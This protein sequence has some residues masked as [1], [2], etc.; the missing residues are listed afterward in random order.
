MDQVSGDHLYWVMLKQTFPTTITDT[1]FGACGI[2]QGRRLPR[3]PSWWTAILMVFPCVPYQRNSVSCGTRCIKSWKALVS[4]I[5]WCLQPSVFCFTACLWVFG[6]DWKCSNPSGSL[7][8]RQH[9]LGALYIHRPMGSH[10]FLG[11]PWKSISS[12]TFLG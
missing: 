11:W 9:I 12:R 2:S 6:C 1:G 3:P 8:T 5:P 4:R 7:R 10:C